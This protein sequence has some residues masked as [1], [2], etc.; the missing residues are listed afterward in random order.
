LWVC[1]KTDYKVVIGCFSAN[2]TALRSKSKDWLAWNR[3]KPNQEW[4][5]MST[6]DNESEWS[7]MSTCELLLQCTSSIEIQPSVYKVDIIISSY[8]IGEELLLWF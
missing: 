3:D 5:N 8:D 1:A 7:N 4:S 2:P 6:G